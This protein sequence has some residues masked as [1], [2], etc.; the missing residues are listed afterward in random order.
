VTRQRARI[1]QHPSRHQHLT[2][3]LH[4]RGVTVAAHLG[5]Q[6]G[7]RVRHV[8]LGPRPGVVGLVGSVELL[9]RG[10]GDGERGGH[11]P[12]LRCIGIGR[13]DLR[14]PDAKQARPGEDA[15]GADDAGPGLCGLAA[16]TFQFL[17][18]FGQDAVPARG[19]LLIGGD[20]PE[21]GG[22]E[23]LIWAVDQ[24]LAPLEAFEAAAERFRTLR[25]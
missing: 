8:L 11:R 9:L 3:L 19:L 5:R 24:L 25:R 22:F 13:A 6:L 1:A 15:Q 14:Q 23:G 21:L 17:D 20:P 4:E 2:V 16:A 12:V 7:R 18:T 10:P